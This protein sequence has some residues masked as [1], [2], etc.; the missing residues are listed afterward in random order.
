MITQEDRERE[1]MWAWLAGVIDTHGRVYRNGRQAVR[2]DISLP[3]EIAPWVMKNI[4]GRLTKRGV[5]ITTNDQLRHVLAEVLPYLRYRRI[6][7]ARILA[8]LRAVKAAP[9][10]TSDPIRQRKFALVLEAQEEWKS[11]AF[12]MYVDDYE[13]PPQRPQDPFAI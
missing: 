6:Q 13:P 1:L 5:T 8:W 2:L 7:V 12:P 10:K 4:G 9:G 3:P 11:P